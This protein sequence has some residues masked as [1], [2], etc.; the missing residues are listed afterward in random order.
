[1]TLWITESDPIELRPDASEGDLQVVI[2]AVYKQVLGNAHVMESERLATAESQLMNGE[3]TVRG[4]VKAVAQSDLY[5]SLFFD[6]TSSY[7]FIELNYKHLLGRAPQEQSEIAE[8]VQ[9]YSTEGYEAD[10]NSYLNSLEYQL[11]F[12]E[13][14]VPYYRGS[15]TIVGSKN[16]G[17]N[18]LFALMSGYA[19]SDAGK[20]ARLIGDVAGNQPT[21][22]KAPAKGSGA[23]SAAGKRFRIA[24]TKAS[25]G[26]RVTRSNTTFEVGYGQ[27]SR[28]IQNI[29]K[30]G[31]RILSITEVA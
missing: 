28:K 26:P 3:I 21:P 9:T 8:H 25:F 10:I 1:M 16:V 31:G 12:G 4:F 19:A 11:N 15:N 30:T 14:I 18:R 17:F 2:R 7:R 29:Q 27:L 24:V 13:N 23:T 22:I 6:T 5:R 20:S